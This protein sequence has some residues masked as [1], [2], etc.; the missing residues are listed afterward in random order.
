MLG[1]N[2]YTCCQNNPVNMSDDSG[3]KA[4]VL[5]ENLF[6]PNAESNSVY[7]RSGDIY[8]DEK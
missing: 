3:S 6:K 4:A 1:H 8:L 2:A 5:R 7:L